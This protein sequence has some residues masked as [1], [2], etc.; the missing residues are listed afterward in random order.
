[1]TATNTTATEHTML[2]LT[3]HGERYRAQAAIDRFNE[4]AAKSG[5]GHAI[6]WHGTEAT[7]AEMAIDAIDRFVAAIDEH[8]VEAAMQTAAKIRE[9]REKMIGWFDPTSTSTSV[10]SSAVNAAE[11]KGN[12][13]IIEMMDEFA[14]AYQADLDG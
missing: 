7:V 11:Y 8:G 4:D 3:V 10:M 1:M 12:R 6:Q 2:D 5:I 14:A 13:F 9:A